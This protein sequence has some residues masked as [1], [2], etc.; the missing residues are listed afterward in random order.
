MVALGIAGGVL[1]AA[2]LPNLAG[3][4]WLI[5]AVLFVALGP[6]LAGT[7]AGVVALIWRGERSL[8]I[9]VPLL[10]VVLFLL[11]EVLIPH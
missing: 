11:V 4:P 8:L 3:Y 9:L 10:L 5:A 2:G 6:A 7:A 1:A